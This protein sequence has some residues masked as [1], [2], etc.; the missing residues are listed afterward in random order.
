MESL[1]FD[2]LI[3]LFFNAISSKHAIFNP[4]LF[5]IVETNNEA[6]NKSLI[7]PVSNHEL[8]LPIAITF[9]DLIFWYFFI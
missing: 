2:L 5:S 9:K 4:C 6:S 7:F 3:Q 1:I 8:P